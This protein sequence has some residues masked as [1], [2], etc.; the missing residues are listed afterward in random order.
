MI[1]PLRLVDGRIHH[2]TAEFS[3]V[4]SYFCHKPQIRAAEV[5]KLVSQAWK[6]LSDEDRSH[7]LELGRQDRQRY[8]REKAAYTGPWKVP[9]VKDPDTP[10]RPMSAFL[11][12][13]NERRKVIVEENP[14][15]SGSEISSALS[16]LW[17]ECPY[18]VKQQYREREAKERSIYKKQRAVWKKRATAPSPESPVVVE[19]TSSS[20]AT[21]ST[22]PSEDSISENDPLDMEDFDDLMALTDAAFEKQSSFLSALG[23]IVPFDFPVMQS[24]TFDLP[25][26]KTTS[27]ATSVDGKIE[28]PSRFENYTMDDILKDDELFEDFSPSQV[29][30]ID[31]APINAS[32]PLPNTRSETHLPMPNVGFLSGFFA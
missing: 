2:I 18:E 10:K 5:A 30:I 3:Q 27:S 19:D 6:N 14:Q 1:R 21:S 22:G 29:K 24:E 31:R 25:P 26:T 7:W 16:K 20:S 28:L 15:L 13:S 32:F 17:K 12:F 9:D 23:A 4:V 11:A 8:E